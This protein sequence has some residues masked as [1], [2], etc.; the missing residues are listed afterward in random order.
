MANKINPIQVNEY[1]LG[2]PG[3]NYNLTFLG[4][5]VDIF[6]HQKKVLV[7]V[8]NIDPGEFNNSEIARMISLKT[9]VETFGADTIIDYITSVAANKMLGK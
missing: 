7:S 8:E 9:F 3:K 6:S 4:S 1:P 2:I 5:R